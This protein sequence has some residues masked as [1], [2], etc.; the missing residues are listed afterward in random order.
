MAKFIGNGHVRHVTANEV[1]RD[2]CGVE[3]NALQ[4]ALPSELANDA[5]DAKK[6]TRKLGYALRDQIKVRYENESGEEFMLDRAGQ[7]RAN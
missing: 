1:A 4:E 7:T 6:L 2:I 3:R 5:Q